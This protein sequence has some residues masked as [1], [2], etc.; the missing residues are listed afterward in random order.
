TATPGV[1][2]ASLPSSTVLAAGATATNVMVTP[3]PDSLSEGDETVTL[4]LSASPNYQLTSLSNAT[5]VIKDRPLDDW[6]KS[7][8]VAGELTNASISGD[9]ADPDGDGLVSLMEFAMGLPPKLAN[10][11]ALN[12]RIES[13]Q[14][15][16]T[17]ARNKA[18]TD[19]L[20]TLETSTDLTTWSA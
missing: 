14:F 19:L 5:A 6:R 13:G 3:I 7:N 2:Y 17:Y 16:I 20:L 11:N 10:M 15:M 12:P 1:D 9:L 18:A 8:F 4:T